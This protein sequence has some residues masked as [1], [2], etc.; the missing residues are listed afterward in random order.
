MCGPF[1]RIRPNHCPPP[2][3]SLQVVRLARIFR[4]LYP[5][6]RAA[7]TSPRNALRSRAVLARSQRVGRGT[8]C[9]AD[10]LTRPVPSVERCLSDDIRNFG[11]YS[12]SL[13]VDVRPVCPFY[14]IHTITSADVSSLPYVCDAASTTSAHRTHALVV[15]ADQSDQEVRPELWQPP[16]IPCGPPSWP[17]RSSSTLHGQASAQ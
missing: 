11:I 5:V 12:S 4:A 14:N 15:Q 13:D 2:A 3:S 1:R 6:A 9:W 7:P 8:R 10:D 16:R 17:L